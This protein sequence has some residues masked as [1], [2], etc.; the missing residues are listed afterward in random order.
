MRR[1]ISV[2]SVTYPTRAEGLADRLYTCLVSPTRAPAESHPARRALPLQRD[3]AAS[4]AKILAA[5]RAVFAERG[6]AGG[7]I[8]EIARRAGVTHGL[9]MRHFG[10]K[11]ALLVAALPGV[12]DL[13]RALQGPVQTL[14][15][16]TVE[17]F[18]TQVDTDENNT[19]VTLIRS[20][21]S[22]QDA[23]TPLRVELERQTMDAFRQVLGPDHDATIELLRAFLLGVAFNRHVAPTPALAAMTRDQ[24]AEQMLPTVRAIL[25]PATAASR[26]G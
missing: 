15:Q 20:A 21:A 14:A 4:K 19:L 26:N 6:Y 25:A 22:G 18:V 8:R 1:G 11:E 23:T 12:R 13:S 3:A 10:S 24:L 7:S 5:A 16:R 9:V 2:Q 17:V